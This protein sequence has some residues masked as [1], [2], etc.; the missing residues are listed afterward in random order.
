MGNTSTNEIAGKLIE[1][2]KKI[3]DFQMD[4]ENGY[5]QIF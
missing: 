1:E 5:M 3:E 2:K 4:H